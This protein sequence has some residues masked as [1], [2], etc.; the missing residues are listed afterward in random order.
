MHVGCVEAGDLAA[1]RAQVALKI[2]GDVEDV[3][4]G[5]VRAEVERVLHD[6]DVVHAALLGRVPRHRFWMLHIAHV[7]DLQ[8]AVHPARR[9]VLCPLDR[10]IEIDLIGDEDVLPAVALPPRGVGTAGEPGTRYLLYLAIQRVEVVLV[11]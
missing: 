11:L 1:L 9:G 10:A 3:E 6:P 4:P 2:T 7:D 8:R 5:V